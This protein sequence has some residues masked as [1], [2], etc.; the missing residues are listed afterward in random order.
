MHPWIHT[1]SRW[2][3]LGICG[4]GLYRNHIRSIVEVAKGTM[5]APVGIRTRVSASKGPNDWPLHYWSLTA[6]ITRLHIIVVEEYTPFGAFDRR[7]VIRVHIVFAV[8]TGI[9]LSG[10]LS[11][12]FTVSIY[13]RIPLYI[14][15][16][17]ISGESN[18]NYIN[19]LPM[20]LTG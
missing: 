14:G 18:H 2:C 4:D 13:N 8:S 10:L 16:A 1:G 5:S 3:C 6:S 15:L 11:C 7:M 12:V 20:N 9:A 17:P 19:G